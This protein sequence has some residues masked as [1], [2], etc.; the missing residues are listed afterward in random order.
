MTVRIFPPEAPCPPFDTDR[1][2]CILLA[3]LGGFDLQ[4]DARSV[5]LPKRAQRLLVFLA[6]C[7]RPV[8]RAYVADSLWLDASEGHADGNLRSALWRLGR[9]GPHVVAVGDG[10]LA[11]DPGVSV[12]LHRS[13]ALAKRLLDPGMEL[14]GADLDESLLSEDLLPDWYEDWVL[15][16]RE[17][18]RHLRLH[19]LELLCERLVGLGRFGQA[20]QAGLAAVAGEPL[21]ESAQR[22][23][24]EAYLAEGNACDALQQYGVYRSLLHD[25]LGREPS[26]RIK[27]L[28]TA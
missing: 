7:S 23:L 22:V 2:P 1:P 10:S 13:V 24:I 27:S 16:E 11:L 15:E 5:R 19:A 17:R 28:V 12:D 3:V 20:V 25:E 21:R 4:M 6:L 8:A 18:Y 14:A 9:V 26:A